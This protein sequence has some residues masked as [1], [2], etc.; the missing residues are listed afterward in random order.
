MLATMPAEV[1]RTNRVQLRWRGAVLSFI[2]SPSRRAASFVDAAEPKPAESN[3][4]CCIPVLACRGVGLDAAEV[5]GAVD[6]LPAGDL[7]FRSDSAAT[8]SPNR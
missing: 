2:G 8:D 4:R 6:A 3:R 7:G 5:L 1:L